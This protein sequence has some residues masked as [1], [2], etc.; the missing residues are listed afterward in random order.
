MGFFDIFRKKPKIAADELV[1]NVM[2]RSVDINGRHLDMPCGLKALT[3]M[4]GK[5][6]MFAGKAGNLNAVWDKLGVYCYLSGGDVY[7][8]GIKAHP[9]EIPA[10][11]EPNRL[12]VGK[13]IVCGEEWEQAL[14]EGTDLEIGRERQ[15]NSISLF[16]SYTDFENRDSN[17]CNGAYTGIEIQYHRN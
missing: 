12:F 1:I 11:F 17:G 16:G 14:S 2:E 7:C 3:D 15:M 4:L 6:R 10:G 13:L 8:L 9:E 5:P